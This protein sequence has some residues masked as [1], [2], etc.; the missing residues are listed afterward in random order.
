MAENAHA[1]LPWGEV[2]AKE[3]QVLGC[4][5]MAAADYPDLLALIASGAV[6][7]STLVGRVAPL[8]EAG[9]ELMALDAPVPAGSGMVILQP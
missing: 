7:P 9:A 1:S 3:L 2:V 5:G 4:H 6:D 8:A